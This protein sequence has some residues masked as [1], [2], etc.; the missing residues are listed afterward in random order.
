ML[1]CDAKVYLL[2]TVARIANSSTESTSE[3]TSGEN[4]S[5]EVG[6]ICEKL[7]RV[8]PLL[9]YLKCVIAFKSCLPSV[10]LI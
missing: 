2:V 9:Q 6:G 8:F 7:V 3:V 4:K 5:Q 1:K 10:W